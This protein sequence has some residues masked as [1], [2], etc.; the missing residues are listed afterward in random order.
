VTDRCTNNNYQI[1]SEFN[2]DDWFMLPYKVKAYALGTPRDGDLV[3]VKE[4][5]ES[6]L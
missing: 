5:D 1:L 6:K 3:A 2:S 4:G